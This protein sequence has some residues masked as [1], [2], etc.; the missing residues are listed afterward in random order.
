M[1]CGGTALRVSG[2]KIAD[3]VVWED[4]SGGGVSRIF[5]LPS[6]QE[7]AGVPSA[8]NPAGP[9][10]RGVPDVAG[11]ADPATG[12]KVLVDGQNLTF[13]GT[14][15]VAPL[16]AGLIARIN[17]K[18]GHNAG[19]INTI[20]YQNP[21]ACNDITSGSNIDYNAGPGWDPCTGLGSPQGAA[22]LQA[23]SGSGSSGT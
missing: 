1:G 17:Q 21:Q 23:L 16:W 22:I 13:G 6:Y 18:L 9:V 14:S 20:L 3:E 4:H 7:N 15:A 12:Y 8:V 11:D 10:R 2:T 19:F 5:N